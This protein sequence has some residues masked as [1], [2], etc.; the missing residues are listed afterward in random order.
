MQSNNEYIVSVYMTTYYHEKYIK[1]AIES[2][3]SQKVSFKYEIVISDDA[4]QDRT[5]EILKDYEKKYDFIK[6]NL[7][8][9][10]L[11]LTANMFLAKTMCT[12]KYIIPLSGDDYWIDEYKLQ[13]QV[14][15]LENNL[16]YI[17]ITTRL[18]VR[19][20]VANTADF[21]IPPIKQCNRTMSLELF[22]KGVI[23]PTNGL[24]MRNIIHD[25]IDFFS[26]MPKVSKF[27]DDTTD[28]ILILSIGD[29]Y[30][31]SDV[32]VAYRRRIEEVGAHNFNSINDSKT[33]FMKSVSLLNGIE[34]HLKDKYD[35]FHLYKRSVSRTIFKCHR[36]FWKRDLKDVYLSIPIKYRKR[37]LLIRS[38]LTIP[39]R[40][41]EVIRNRASK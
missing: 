35:L 11:G 34:E 16:K 22:L 37:G 39:I 29:V 21:I 26:V 30:I 4:S 5:P 8:E 14:D 9:T 2:I 7:N 19:T 40:A 17:G 12:G 38:I 36:H 6:I 25:N 20:D 15:F 28:C 27:I 10:N 13:K 33:I 32:T 23:F 18:E 1:Q 41:V 24:M 3:L 31:S